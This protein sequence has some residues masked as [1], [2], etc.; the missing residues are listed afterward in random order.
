MSSSYLYTW[1]R[2]CKLY[3]FPSSLLNPNNSLD[4]LLVINPVS[5]SF[6]TISECYLKL[7]LSTSV[8]SNVI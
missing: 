7:P 6:N 3:A 5:N 8:V 4:S 1:P 2:D